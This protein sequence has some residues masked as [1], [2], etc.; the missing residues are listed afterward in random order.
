MAFFFIN[1]DQEI[2]SL[3]VV[4]FSVIFNSN[5]GNLN[6]KYQRYAFGA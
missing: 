1:H 3:P 4:L 6:I 5:L 2:R